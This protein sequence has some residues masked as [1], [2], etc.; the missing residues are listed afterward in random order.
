MNPAPPLLRPLAP[1]R[2]LLDREQNHQTHK[3][4]QPRPQRAQ[5]EHTGR[6]REPIGEL[7]EDKD[8]NANRLGGARSAANFEHVMADNPDETSPPERVTLHEERPY[9]QDFAGL[10]AAGWRLMGL[11]ENDRALFER[12]RLL[13]ENEHDMED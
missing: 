12:R 9:R 8:A 3:P 6:S 13:E 11:K 4:H 5:E 2:A 7:D 10:L 1:Q